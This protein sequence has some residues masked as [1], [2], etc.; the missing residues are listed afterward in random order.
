[1]GVLTYLYD[2]LQGRLYKRVEKVNEIIMIAVEEYVA[3]GEVAMAEAYRYCQLSERAKDLLGAAEDVGN[4]RIA[5]VEGI[6]KALVLNLGKL[7]PEDIGRDLL[8]LTL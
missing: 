1:M 5:I 8:Q 7:I 2:V 6:G 3:E 4:A